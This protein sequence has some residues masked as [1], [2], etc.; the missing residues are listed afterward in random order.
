MDKSG[1]PRKLV[2]FS[3]Y[4]VDKVYSLA[5]LKREAKDLIGLLNLFVDLDILNIH[6]GPQ[7]LKM[8]GE[9]TFQAG[10]EHAI[11]DLLSVNKKKL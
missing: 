11:Q 3:C 9:L 8:Y 1:K 5:Y 7:L 4:K 6:L 10:K 2:D